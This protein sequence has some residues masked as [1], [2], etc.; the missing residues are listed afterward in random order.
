MD[1]YCGIFN[2]P[3]VIILIEFSI[4]CVYIIALVAETETI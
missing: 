1:Y 4:M 3:L 2:C